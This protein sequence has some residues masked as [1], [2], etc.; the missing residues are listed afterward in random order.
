MLILILMMMTVV[1]LVQNKS[2]ADSTTC[3]VLVVG[4]PLWATEASVAHNSSRTPP[5]VTI[6]AARQARRLRK[7]CGHEY[8]YN[9]R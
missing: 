3:S 2:N 8:I 7:D 5:E 4:A 6:W 1:M 9:K